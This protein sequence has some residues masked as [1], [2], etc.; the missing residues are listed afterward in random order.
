MIL[1]GTKVVSFESSAAEA[2]GKLREKKER[3]LT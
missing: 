3:R 1:L 2:Y